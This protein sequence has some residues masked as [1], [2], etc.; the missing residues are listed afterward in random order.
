[1]ISKTVIKLTQLPAQ[2]VIC[3]S[4]AIAAN[5]SVYYGEWSGVDLTSL[6]RST[7]ISTLSAIATLIALFCSLS[8][9]WII[10]ITQQTKTERFAA[11]DLMKSRLFEAQKWLLSM[12]DTVDREIC[13]SLAHELDKFSLSD[14]PRTNWGE[15]DDS[16][17]QALKR[18][19]DSD[20]NRRREFYLISGSHFSYIE[21]QLSRIGIISI[22]QIIIK[23]FIDTLAKGVFLVALSVLVL[24]SATLLF[25]ESIKPSYIVVSTF[26]AVGAALLLVE[27]WVDLRREYDD[28]LDFIE[29]EDEEM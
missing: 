21:N 28:D 8:I 1:M 3:T 20:D 24:I 6:D 7:F 27:V 14:F 19:L 25:N 9:T 13:L 26:I 29:S 4:C 16:Y 12:P 22:R 18:G 5:L 11:Y 15:E 23:L 10:F 2:F 17:C